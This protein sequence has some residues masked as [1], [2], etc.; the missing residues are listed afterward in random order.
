MESQRFPVMCRFLVSE[1]IKNNNDNIN[2]NTYFK[3]N[4]VLH[5]QQ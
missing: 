1:L 5:I 4:N 2:N 3:K